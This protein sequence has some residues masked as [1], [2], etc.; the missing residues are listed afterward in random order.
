[1]HSGLL[2]E[3]SQVI[4]KM[5]RDRLLASLLTDKEIV[6]AHKRSIETQLFPE[7]CRLNCAIAV[8]E[9]S[10]SRQPEERERARD[11]ALEYLE[12]HYGERMAFLSLIERRIVCLFSWP[13]RIL[14][15]ELRKHAEGA[16][17]IAFSV[18]VGLPRPDL[19]S[20][21]ASLDQAVSALSEK[22]YAS[23]GIY[24]YT[25][26]QA[27]VPHA[28][29]PCAEEKAIIEH[30]RTGGDS[31][32]LYSL[33]DQFFNQMA[34]ERPSEHQM[35]YSASMRLVIKLESLFFRQDNHEVPPDLP[36]LELTRCDTLTALKQFTL[37]LILEML[38]HKDLHSRRECSLVETSIE[39]MKKHC[40]DITLQGLAELVFITPNYLSMLFKTQTGKTFIE[41]LTDIRIAA[42]KTM[43]E[44]TDLKNYEICENV[45]YQD[46]R[47]FGKLFKQKVGLTPSEYRDSVKR[48]PTPLKFKINR[49]S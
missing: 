17:D 40:G 45:G 32:Q 26:P 1:M 29:Y 13:D 16:A 8:F 41:T 49:L 10:C 31:V 43:I 46:P 3:F 12:Q 47:Y 28:D 5:R 38:E 25:S 11:A 20:L 36:L 30:I 48:S 18:G 14:L 23:T 24:L 37:N 44:E 4:Q 27:S 33:L 34:F 21:H 7:P 35:F 2:N 9:V 6:E 22:F 15:E 19:R 39:H 42:A